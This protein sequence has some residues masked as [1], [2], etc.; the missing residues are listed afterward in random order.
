[1]VVMNCLLRLVGFTE[2]APMDVIGGF[3]G[4]NFNV[5]SI[6]YAPSGAIGPMANNWVILIIL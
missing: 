1:M 6:G 5:V 2:M 3:N 4:S